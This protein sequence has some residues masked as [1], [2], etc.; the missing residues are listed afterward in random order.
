MKSTF[1]VLLFILSASSLLA[2]KETFDLATFTVPTGWKKTNSTASVVSY[3]VTNNQ[4]GTYCQIGVYASTNSK[5]NVQAD[6]ESEWQEL[7]VKTYKPTTK[8]EMMPAASEN[9]WDAQGGASS[10]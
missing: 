4:K 6:F 3:A 10:L 9:G 2:Q 5:G 8:P 1:G 7:V